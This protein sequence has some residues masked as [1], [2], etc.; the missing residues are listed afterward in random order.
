MKYP[1]NIIKVILFYTTLILFTCVNVSLSAA[2]KATPEEI[3]KITEAIPATIQ[4][5]KK[6]KVLVFSKAFTYYH[7][8]IA[9][10]TW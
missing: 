2:K 1:F 6:Y 7:S 10:A 4:S 8:S 5:A 9:V 3:Q